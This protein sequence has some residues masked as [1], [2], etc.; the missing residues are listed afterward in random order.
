MFE[1][2]VLCCVSCWVPYR[3]ERWRWRT[4][5]ET[6]HVLDTVNPG[7][8][9]FG[10]D[11]GHLAWAGA[12]PAALIRAYADRVTGIHVK[13]FRGDIA[14]RGKAE[15]WDYRRTVLAGLWA[16]PGHGTNDITQ[17]LHALNHLNHRS[18]PCQPTSTAT[19]SSSAAGSWGQA[20][21]ASSAMPCPPPAS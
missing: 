6:R 3:P 11:M 19:C 4:E 20:S 17:V 10:P 2:V 13:D 12:D 14:D 21:P 7:V 5:A 8:L 16:E 1:R 15:G 9:V 18:F